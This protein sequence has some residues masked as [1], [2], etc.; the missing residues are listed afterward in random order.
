MVIDNGRGIAQN[1]QED[2]FSIKAAPTYCTNNEKGV[3][4]GLV[5]CKEFVERNGGRIGFE[6]VVGKGSRFFIY[7]PLALFC[8]FI[9]LRS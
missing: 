5:L 1:D 9:M 2:V 7:L 8:K 6:S 4:L 3:G